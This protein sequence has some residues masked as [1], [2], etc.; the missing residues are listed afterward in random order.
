M[1]T[2]HMSY[3]LIDTKMNVVLIEE[4]PPAGGQHYVFKSRND[5]CSHARILIL[6]DRAICTGLP[7]DWYADHPQPSNI[8]DWGC[9]RLVIA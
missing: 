1:H 8:I 7:T 4:L 2:C 3:D 6:N 5:I 9:F